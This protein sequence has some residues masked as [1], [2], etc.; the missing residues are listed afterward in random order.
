MRKSSENILNR[1]LIALM[2]C[3]E[4]NR[5]LKIL[6]LVLAGLLLCYYIAV[7]CQMGSTGWSSLPTLKKAGDGSVRR[8]A[9]YSSRVEQYCNAE[10]R[11]AAEGNSF[12]FIEM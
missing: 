12:A 5:S 11:S 6:V 8:Y 4:K 2:L 7:F 10:P 1:Q 9:H 3:F